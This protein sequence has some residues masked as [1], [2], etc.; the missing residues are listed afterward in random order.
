MKEINLANL[1]E[2]ELAAIKALEK[3]L[4]RV[5]LV[6]VEKKEAFFAVE[7]KLGPNNWVPVSQAFPEMAGLASYYADREDA[8]AA[9]SSLK[10]LLTGRPE[11]RPIKKPIRIRKI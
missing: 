11:L 3:E 5:C 8:Q 10:S 4:G 2:E 6:A 1:S 7:A 9:K